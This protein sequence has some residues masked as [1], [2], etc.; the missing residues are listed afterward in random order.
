MSVYYAILEVCLAYLMFI[1]CVQFEFHNVYRFAK[2]VAIVARLAKSIIRKN[3][4]TLLECRRTQ[5]R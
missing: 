3:S 4:A 5:C 2:Q 1:Y